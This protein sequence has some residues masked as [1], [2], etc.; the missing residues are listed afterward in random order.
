M[1]EN[2]EQNE[3]RVDGIQMVPPWRGTE[4]QK[5]LK[6]IRYGR[7]ILIIGPMF[8]C[9]TQ[10]LMNRMTI[11]RRRG[12]KCIIIRH[13]LD[14]RFD[15]G[16]KIKTHDGHVIGVD[17]EHTYR[18]QL[19]FGQLE[20]FM[21]YDV[22]GIDEGQWFANPR[23]LHEFS[24]SLVKM[25][26]EV[27]IAGL[28]TDKD[29]KP[30]NVIKDLMPIADKIVLLR[31]VCRRCGGKAIFTNE[32]KKMEPKESN[33][34]SEQTTD[35]QK[36]SRTENIGEYITSSHSA[37]AENYVKVGTDQDYEALCRLCYDTII[38]QS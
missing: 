22:I 28:L 7:L 9:K 11:H 25:G 30:Y 21:S 12:K 32:I 10:N 35:L 26:K 31:A 20:G 18:I 38:M 8:S 24:L 19:D 6:I 29:L 16:G 4:N 15:D 5:R 37:L 2:L 27:I 36:K 14:K 3:I 23:E 17:T 13:G 34:I 33:M 1:S